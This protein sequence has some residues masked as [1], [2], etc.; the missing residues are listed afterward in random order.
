MKRLF[1]SLYLLISLSILGIGW[2]LDNIWQNNVDDS[3][4]ADAPLIMLAQLLAKLPEQDRIGYLAQIDHA[5]NYPIELMD[6]SQIALSDKSDL[7]DKAVLIT[8]LSD[9]FELHFIKVDN[10]ILVA[11]PIEI[12]PRARLRKLFTLFFY[13]SLGL[14]ALIWVWP[15][16]RDLKVLRNATQEFGQAKWDT[17]IKLSPRSQVIPLGNTFNEMARQISTLIEN[18]KHLSNAVSHEIRT[19]LARLKFALALMPQYCKPDSDKHRRSEFI[20]EM[21]LDVKEIDKL[22]QELLTYASLESQ[23]KDIHLEHC[24]LTALTRQTIKRLSS[25]NTPPIRY[26][27]NT[28]TTYLLGDPSLIER[29][30]QNLVTNA[31]RFAQHAIDI[32]IKQSKQFISLSVTNDGP[33]IPPE[34]QGK[35]FEPFYRSKSV[36]NGNKG[37][38]LGLAIIKRIM[39]RHNGTVKLE[40]HNGS[41]RFILTWP[42]PE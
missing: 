35:I 38:G 12:D 26:N 6:S 30:I 33:D 23:R 18:Q 32:E 9:H 16:S 2:T 1:I 28:L 3:G 40:S 34:D 5:P 20:E 31:Q 7:T 13:L 15:L 22:L 25:Q 41:T 10:Q 39:E 37:H 17:Q 14:I 27:E 24:D 19:P 4:A 8:T 21:L 42:K 36:Q 11:G 29:A